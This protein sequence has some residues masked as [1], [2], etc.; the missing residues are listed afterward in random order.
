MGE[1]NGD[2]DDAEQC[3][4]SLKSL[5]HGP[6]P[7]RWAASTDL[8]RTVVVSEA[9]AKRQHSQHL[10]HK[11]QLCH[12]NAKTSRLCWA[13]YL[14]TDRPRHARHAMTRQNFIFRAHHGVV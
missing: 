2:H 11:S 9:A 7:V 5:S 8:L 1:R 14:S 6:L 4:E 13:D 3:E 10:A 12:L